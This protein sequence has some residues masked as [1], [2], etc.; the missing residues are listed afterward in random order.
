MKEKIFSFT[1][2]ICVPTA[3]I[4]KDNFKRIFKNQVVKTHSTYR[5][6]V[7][8]SIKKLSQNF[9]KNGCEN[10]SILP[11]TSEKRQSQIFFKKLFKNQ[12]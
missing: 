6:Q 8:V 1:H 4:V 9:L 11:Y 2:K 12:M 5:I 10:V 7:K 3:Y